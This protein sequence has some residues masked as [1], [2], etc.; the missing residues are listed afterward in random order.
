[1]TSLTS[2]E[3]PEK[4]AVHFW[5]EGQASLFDFAIVASG[6]VGKRDGGTERLAK[7]INRHPSTVERYAKGGLLWLAM[8]EQYPSQAEILR[9]GLE[10]SYWNDVGR[11]YVSKLMDLSQAKAS[12][13]FAKEQGWTVEKLRTMLPT[14]SAGHSTIRAKATQAA[15]FLEDE[16]I[17]APAK[18]V[19]EKIYKVTYKLVKVAIVWLRKLSAPPN[20]S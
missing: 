11:A 18:D 3:T 20:G 12:L 19:D 13:E 2:T 14:K 16:I 5:N 8:L 6:I 4:A 17:K 7:K 1:M 10:I 9:D 15:N